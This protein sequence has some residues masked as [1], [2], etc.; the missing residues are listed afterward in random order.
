MTTEESP[1]LLIFSSKVDIATDYVILKLEKLGARF[2]RINAEDFP[3]EVC[4]SLTVNNS[5]AG[6]ELQWLAAINKHIALSKVR[7]VWFRRHRMAPMPAEMEK[8]HQE[9]CLREADWFIKGLIYSLDNKNPEVRWM[10]HPG[11]AQFAESKIYQLSVARTLGLRVPKTLVSNDPSAVRGF[12]N[13]SGGRMI[14]KPL[15]LGYFDFGDRQTCV[16]TTLIAQEHLLDTEAIQLAPV[17]YQELIPKACD[18]RVTIVGREL[19]SASIDSQ[20]VPS[21]RVDWRQS[22]TEDLPHSVHQLPQDIQAK[23]LAYMD[24]LGLSFGALDL[25]LTPHNEYV[26][27]EVN[28]SGQWVWIEDKLN[29]PISETIAEWLWTSV[30]A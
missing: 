20:S 18:I 4:A 26:F 21:A 13:E 9:Y 2:F 8:A 30:R 16:F 1:P 24:A 12:W 28:S 19:F 11:R 6:P 17:I 3:L 25:V 15:R 22:E 10:N 27:L 7:S 23:C 14:G 5:A 29:L